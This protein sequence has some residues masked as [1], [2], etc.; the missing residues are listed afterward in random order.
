V[1]RLEGR[2]HRMSDATKRCSR[3]KTVKATTEFGKDST[4]RDQLKRHCRV[5][6]RSVS[7]ES[8]ASDPGRARAND[9]RRY[10][11]SVEAHDALLEVQG[12]RCAICKGFDVT[13]RR[14]SVDH[15]HATGRVRGL[16]CG[17]CNRGLGLF[18]DSEQFLTAACSYLKRGV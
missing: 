9:L 1:T 8:R 10:G 14:L 6:A 16:L 17:S 7:A 12:G 5:C 18:K 15:D 2:C 3:C 4:R 11:L 13:G